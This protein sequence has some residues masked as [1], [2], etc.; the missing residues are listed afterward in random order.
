M[1]SRRYHFFC[2]LTFL[3]LSRCLYPD[4]VRSKTLSKQILFFEQIWTSAAQN[5]FLAMQKPSVSTFLALI[6]VNVRQDIQAMEKETVHVSK[7][8]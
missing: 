6:P 2:L 1:V 7:N 5:R 8:V 4:L 3:K